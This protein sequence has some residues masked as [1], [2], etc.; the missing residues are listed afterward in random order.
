[1][2]ALEK[3]VVYTGTDGLI[4]FGAHEALQKTVSFL[5]SFNRF[6]KL[7]SKNMVKLSR[8]NIQQYST[9]ITWRKKSTWV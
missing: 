3:T 6:I 4:K 8:M 9:K 7:S 5:Q 1:M 2:V